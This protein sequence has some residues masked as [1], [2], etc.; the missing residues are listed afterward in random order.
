VAVVDVPLGQWE[1]TPVALVVS[2]GV[3]AEGIKT[4]VNERVG[5]AQRLAD[6]RL[7]TELPRS[8]IGK[9]LKCELRDSY[10]PCRDVNA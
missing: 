10:S 6:A 4:F 1:E 9:I 5:K 7:I 3:S 2:K 8:H